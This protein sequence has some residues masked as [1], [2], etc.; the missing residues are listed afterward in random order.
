MNK[1]EISQCMQTTYNQLSISQSRSSS[2][3]IDII[4]RYLYFNYEMIENVCIL[5]GD[6]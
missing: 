1:S 3:S 6:L 5:N 2:Q 4:S